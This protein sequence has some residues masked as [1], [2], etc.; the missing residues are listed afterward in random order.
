M[1]IATGFIR[2][3]YFFVSGGHRRLSSFSVVS[4]DVLG[5][6]MLAVGGCVLFLGFALF[7][8]VTFLSLLCT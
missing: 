5:M 1:D 7:V 2:R 3:A 4:S 6:F 8:L